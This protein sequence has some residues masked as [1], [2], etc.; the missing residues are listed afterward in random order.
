MAGARAP[1]HYCLCAHRR[2]SNQGTGTSN[3]WPSLMSAQLLVLAQRLCPRL[4]TPSRP[5]AQQVGGRWARSFGGGAQRSVDEEVGKEE[6]KDAA[7][8]RC[9][10]CAAPPASAAAARPPPPRLAPTAAKPLHTPS[11][12]RGNKRGICGGSR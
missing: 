10:S 11:A 6:A 9:A 7:A 8:P 12:G 2:S 3:S 4:V 5:A 1:H